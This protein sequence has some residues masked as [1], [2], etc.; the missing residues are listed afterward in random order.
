MERRKF[1]I[2]L[3]ALAAG[4]S[5]AVGSG[6]FTQMTTTGRDMTVDVVNDD[7]ASIALVPGAESDKVAYIDDHGDLTIDLGAGD[8]INTNSHYLFGDV[9]VGGSAPAD[10]LEVD[11]NFE[12]K[13]G[14]GDLEEDTF[15]QWYTSVYTGGEDEFGGVPGSETARDGDG[16][17]P[18]MFDNDVVVSRDNY[19]FRIQN[20]SS[21]DRD[22]WLGVDSKLGNLYGDGDSGVGLPDDDDDTPSWAIIGENVPSGGY[23]TVAVYVRAGK[24]TRELTRQIRIS[25][26]RDAD[27]AEDPSENGRE[28]P[29]GPRTIGFWR[30]WSGDCTE[31][32]QEN[33]L[34]AT[35][36]KADDAGRT[37]KLGELSLTEDDACPKAVNILSRLDL[38]GEN[39]ANDGA[40]ALAAQLLAAKLNVEGAP[41]DAEEGPRPEGAATGE[42]ADDECED[43]EAGT[44]DDVIENGQAL[45]GE[46]GF[47]GTGSYLGPPGGP[48]TEPGGVT[49]DRRQVA[50]AHADCLDA[51]NNAE[52]A[53]QRVDDD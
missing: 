14:Y 27:R 37:I 24:D 30:N 2:G 47:N 9:A 25:A 45:L 29:G 8:G 26:D 39:R 33:V 42:L 13:H 6:A 28:R 17:V 38:G 20:N 35:L 5:A 1:V 50:L 10:I 49:R 41:E 44:V 22:I 18:P 11:G 19:L 46:I 48:P 3:G 52:L 16:S 15:V 36:G 4:S 21:T 7:M 12:E 31:G 23:I 32:N 34:G 53:F 40:Y 51:F 43:L